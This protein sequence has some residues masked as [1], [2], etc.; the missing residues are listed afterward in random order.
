MPVMVISTFDHI[1]I[2]N[3]VVMPM[4]TIT[5]C[6]NGQVFPIFM[7]KSL[8]NDYSDLAEIQTCLR[9]IKG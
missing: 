2:T 8:Q 6:E 7:G 4:T 1:Q 3:K 5:H 9:I